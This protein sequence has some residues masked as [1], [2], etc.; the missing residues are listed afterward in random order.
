MATFPDIM[1]GHGSQQAIATLIYR[2][3]PISQPELGKRVRLSR[4]AVNKTISVL[5]DNRLVHTVG[6]RRPTRGRPADVLEV[7][8]STNL[9]GVMTLDPSDSSTK[10]SLMRMDGVG[11]WDRTVPH[12]RTIDNE[13]LLEVFSSAAKEMLDVATGKGLHLRAV[14]LVLPGG[15]HPVDGSLETCVHFPNI[16]N[17]PVERTV[18]KITNCHVSSIADMQ[19]LCAGIIAAQEKPQRVAILIWGGGITW[20][21]ASPAEPYGQMLSH[22]RG[23][24]HIQ[25]VR[26]GR[27]CYCGGRGCIEAE[28]GGWAL[29]KQLQ[30]MQPEFADIDLPGLREQAKAGNPVVRK[31]LVEAAE[32][33]GEYFHYLAQASNPDAIL[34]QS[35]LGLPEE[36][37]LPAFRRGLEPWLHPSRR[38]TTEISVIDDFG[39]AAHRG[40]AWLASELFFNPKLIRRMRPVGSASTSK[41]TQSI[42]SGVREEQQRT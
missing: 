33:F 15:I 1:Q 37:L 28:V 38:G 9:V 42:R 8:R 18:R 26:D 14:T 3:G 24:G 4:A 2:E 31:V 22:W 41:R 7:D 21:P 23:F 40:A 30:A 39:Q 25:V 5:R 32:R 20:S 6:T 11:I 34:I 17:L 35:G 10:A 13:S 29:L 16:A 19:A 12:D 36:I 27:P